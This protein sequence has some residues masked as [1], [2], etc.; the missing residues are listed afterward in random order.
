M[1]YMVDKSVTK[2]YSDLLRNFRNGDVEAFRVIY[3][4]WRKP[5]FLFLKKMIGSEEDARDITQDVFSALWEMKEQ[6]D[7]SKDIKSLIYLIAR[8][9]TSNHLR[10]LRSHD[11]YLSNYEFNPE[12]STDLQSIVIEKEIKLLTQYALET[13]PATQR[14]VFEL[15]F[16]NGLSNTQI[17]EELQISNGSVRV[18]LHEARKCIKNILVVSFSFVFL[19]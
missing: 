6:I 7:T 12:D 13:M 14:R 2:E 1:T 3:E 9:I 11:L 10:K 16:Y 4:K 8:R 19:L 15:N 18:H 5:V 17:S